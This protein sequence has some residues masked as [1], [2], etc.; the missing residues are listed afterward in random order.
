MCLLL[1]SDIVRDFALSSYPQHELRMLQRS[2]IHEVLKAV[3]DEGKAHAGLLSYVATFL[4][5]HISKAI[6]LPLIEDQLAMS[7][8]SQHKAG[9][10]GTPCKTAI[11]LQVVSSMTKANVVALCEELEHTGR[12]Q[13]LATAGLIWFLLSNMTC[14]SELRRCVSVLEKANAQ[15]RIPDAVDGCVRGHFLWLLGGDPAC[16]SEVDEHAIWIRDFL[17]NEEAQTRLSAASRAEMT[18]QFAAVLLGHRNTVFALSTTHADV[19]AG[20]QMLLGFI[21]GLYQSLAP[22]A[23]GLGLSHAL[24]CLGCVGF[25]SQMYCHPQQLSKVAAPH[26]EHG[27]VMIRFLADQCM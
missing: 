16:Q 1:P 3:A 26:L 14:V 21:A 19:M 17:A 24:F 5:H 25:N 18:G 15:G 2:F 11:A 12:L 13:N 4:G 8:L 9:C 6:N 27:G 20:S 22:G 7:L 23:G 10:E